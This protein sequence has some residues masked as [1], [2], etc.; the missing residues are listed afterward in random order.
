[1]NLKKFH[2][3]IDTGDVSKIDAFLVVKGNDR[4]VDMWTDGDEDLLTAMIAECCR[5]DVKI[6]RIIRGAALLAMDVRTEI[7][8]G[9]ISGA[10]L[11]AMDAR[12]EI[13]EGGEE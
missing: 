5:D 9:I 11:L 2:E 7:P 1:M 10:D 4:K 8:E 13:P 3:L 6:H 12:T